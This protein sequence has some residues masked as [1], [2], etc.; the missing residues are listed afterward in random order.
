MKITAKKCT[1]KKVVTKKVEKP[2][3]KKAAAKK[4]AAPKATPKEEA[5]AEQ[6]KEEAPAEQP[7]EETPAEQPKEEPKEEAPELVVDTMILKEAD[8]LVDKTPIDGL[9]GKTDEDNLG[10]T[11]AV[12]DEYIRTGVC[13][14]EATA[15]LLEVGASIR[16]RYI[17]QAKQC[18]A[19][20]LLDAMEEANQSELDYKQSKNKRL[21]VELMLIRLCQLTDQKKK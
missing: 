21:L 14:D 12:L 13:K 3:A 11:Y 2:V 4:A 10:F 8:D 19:D 5:P 20:F 6:P 15:K 18:P 7:K 17:E 16:S 1:C 9:C